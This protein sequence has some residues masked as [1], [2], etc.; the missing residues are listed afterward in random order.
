MTTSIGKSI[1]SNFESNPVYYIIHKIRLLT[2][3]ESTN[4]DSDT[5]AP[6]ELVSFSEN[7][8]KDVG[9]ILVSDSL[10]G[11]VWYFLD[12]GAA[13]SLILQFR[14]DVPEATSFRHI[15]TLR[16][17]GV[18]SPAVR[19]RHPVDQKGGPRPT[20][21]MVPDATIEHVNNAQKLHKRLMSPKYVAGELMGQLILEEYM[22]PRN[23]NTIT[24][25][26]VKDLVREKGVKYSVLDISNL[27]M[28]YLHE[29]GMKVWR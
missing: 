9:R 11:V 18:I 13:T 8:L 1:L 5:L 28:D 16:K 19:S 29:R 14:V 12:Y 2:L 24:G 7:D 4:Y 3:L 27:A 20:I 10:R 21:W 22:Q 6:P 25:R 26:E 15:T 23:L 17:M